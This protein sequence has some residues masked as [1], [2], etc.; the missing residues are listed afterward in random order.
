MDGD[1]DLPQMIAARR[2]PRRFASLCDRRDD[3]RSQ[4]PN[5]SHCDHQFDD[6]ESATAIGR[7]SV[8]GS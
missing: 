3:E 8:H 4:D 7:T 1:A 6:R 2:P 5:D